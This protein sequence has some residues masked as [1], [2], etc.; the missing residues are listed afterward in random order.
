MVKQGY[1]LQS[2]SWGLDN[3]ANGDWPADH[4]YAQRER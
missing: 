2:A 1:L 4:R 3:G